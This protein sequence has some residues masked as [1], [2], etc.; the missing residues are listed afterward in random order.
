MIF[1]LAILAAIFAIAV[2]L[3]WYFNR[4]SA[5]APGPSPVPGP[6]PSAPVP[7]VP[8]EED[9]EDEDVPAPSPL[10]ENEGLVCTA[11]YRPVC[12][13]DGKT[14]GNACGAA[15]K[16]VEVAREGPCEGSTY[17]T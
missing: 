8:V 5:P 13:V 10:C 17:Y 12:G 1:W 6:G 3:Y 11:E 2:G 7:S 9:E 14:Y 4:P 16:C 15:S